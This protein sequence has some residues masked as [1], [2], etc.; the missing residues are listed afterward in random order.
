MQRHTLEE[1]PLIHWKANASQHM[2]LLQVAEERK[3]GE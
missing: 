2:V 1:S 3:A